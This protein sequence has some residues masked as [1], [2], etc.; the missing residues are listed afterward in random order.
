[1]ELKANRSL[2]V[3]LAILAGYAVAWIAAFSLGNYFTDSRGFVVW[4]VAAAL[5]VSLFLLIGW[6][7]WPA[8]P[9]VAAIRWAIAGD[10]FGLSFPV[11][12]LEQA[13][14]GAWYALCTRVLVERL[15][16]RFPLASLRDVA[17]FAV[18]VVA[19]APAIAGVFQVW[20][21]SNH[22]AL[23]VGSI[24]LQYA[25]NLAGN[26]TAMIVVVPAITTI[27]GWKASKTPWSGPRGRSPAELAIGTLA[28]VA[29]VAIDY[30]IGPR[31]G[32]PLGEFAFVPLGVLALRWG[33]RGA[34]AGML[35]ADVTSTALF[36]AMHL[37]TQTLIGYQIF[38]VSSAAMALAIGVMAQERDALIARVQTV[39]YVDE[40]TKLPTRMAFAEWMRGQ[41]GHPVVLAMLDVNDM[42]RLNEG[43]GRAAADRVLSELAARLRGGLDA[44]YFVSRVSS[45]DF[46]VASAAVDPQTVVA[47]IERLV[48][49]P[50]D[51]GD[52]RVFVE[53]SIGV[54]RTTSPENVDDALRHADIALRH[55]KNEATGPAVYST[56]L[57]AARNPLLAEELHEALERDELVP[58]FQPIR[59]YAK[60]TGEWSL[61]GAEAL[62]RWRHPQRGIVFPTEFLDI[63]ERL[64]IAESVGWRVIEESVHFAARCQAQVPGFRVWVN[65]FPRQA[66][67][68]TFASRVAELIAALHA[69]PAWLV[70]EISERIVAGAERD[71][72]SLV[73]ELDAIG[74][75]TAI[76]DFGTGGSSLGRIRDVPARVLKIDKSFVTRSE[77]D[78]KAKTVAAAVV[79][80]GAEL[81]MSVL[82]EGVENAHQVA[83]MIEV[84]CEY[85]QGYAFGHPVPADLFERMVIQSVA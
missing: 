68:P 29:V 83:A 52:A 62:L 76:D 49:A 57:L 79:R 30:A 54:A 56:D 73:A 4:H 31:G 33:V 82:A 63:L 11:V 77:I 15:R 42:R 48:E 53:V 41:A 65:L 27:A 60:E 40:L 12:V 61:D 71:V 13:V 69:D 38:L 35:A 2:P 26:A 9:V 3:T 20:I 84:G 58:F 55:A 70:F 18:V 1:M 75:M 44:T 10:A 67:D 8:V 28:V 19:A 37:P 16:V 78:A 6:R 24:A 46:V 74:V 64:S 80:M 7:F 66:L 22:T 47:G 72:A 14:I 45:D 59:R 85:A 25:R 43:V 39:A 17:W 32:R 51:L 50:F 34:V 36:L 81:D 5:D 21:V 23:A